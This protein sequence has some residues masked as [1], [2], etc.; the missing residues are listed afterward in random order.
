[1]AKVYNDGDTWKLVFTDHRHTRR[2]L[3]LS[4]I[5][6][7]E[8]EKIG[9][10]IEVLVVAKI[11]GEPLDPETA[12]WLA[13][14]GDKLRDR[15]VKLD[16]CAP[17]QRRPQ[18]HLGEF[19]EEYINAQQVKPLTKTM[20]RQTKTALI[21][22]FGANKLL[23]D[24]SEGAAVEWSWWM[25]TPAKDGGHGV[26][27]MT[28]RRNCGRARQFFGH[29]LALG[30]I[31]SNPFKNSKLP[32][33]V[34]ASPASR[35]FFVTREHFE[36]LLAECP[37]Q[38]WRAILALSRIGGLRIPSELTGLKWSDVNWDRGTLTIHSP[39]LERYAGGTRLIPLFPELRRELGD[40]LAVRQ[41][42]DA[43]HGDY[44]ISR[45]RCRNANLRTHFHRLCERAGVPKY[46][47]PFANARASRCTELA[48][49][50][51]VHVVTSWMGHSRT[52]SE[53]HYLRVQA[54]HF[55][56][57][58]G[59]SQKLA[60]ILEQSTT[61]SDCQTGRAISKNPGKSS[62]G[63][64]LANPVKHNEYPRQGQNALSI[65]PV[66]LGECSNSGTHSGTDSTVTHLERI[67]A[68]WQLAMQADPR[69][70]RLAESWPGLSPRDRAAILSCAG[71]LDDPCGNSS[72]GRHP[73]GLVRL[74]QDA[75]PGS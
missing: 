52:V 66:F 42:T 17:K 71:C 37:D 32:T 48:E 8:L 24:I 43:D 75:G 6:R 39:K 40:L 12:R 41:E 56:A 72:T 50:F 15:L 13:E 64:G 19:V 74:G 57:A 33:Q 25:K 11:T 54:E 51:P 5:P 58:T 30:L 20:M 1:M 63:Q 22:Y 9:R 61:V 62:L 23:T 38:E 65:S 59:V 16:L 2:T 3:R 27:E 10:R 68:L 28:A 73:P 47:K 36:A 46:Q 21:N 4:R 7:K 31:D 14:T 34:G 26:G 67:A 60:H 70:A 44:V 69:F 29:A 55:E 18:R 53:R 49:T 45:R 35:E